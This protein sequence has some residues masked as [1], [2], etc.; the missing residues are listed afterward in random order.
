M[1]WIIL[2]VIVIIYFAK[3]FYDR[4]KMLESQVDSNGGMYKKYEVLINYFSNL[5]NSKIVKVTRDHVQISIF[6]ASVNMQYFIT[7]TFGKVEIEWISNSIILG[8]H[9]NKWTFPHNYSQQK[10][11]HEI[12]SFMEWKTKEVFGK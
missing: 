12:E 1:I 2:I 8:N 4:D 5:P 3:F 7:E 11:I 10:M 6:G 9:Q